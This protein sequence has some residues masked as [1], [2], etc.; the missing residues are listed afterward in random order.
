MPICC[1]KV[2]PLTAENLRA[3][4][5][6]W[7]EQQRRPK[8][9]HVFE[10]ATMSRIMETEAATRRDQSLAERSVAESHEPMRLH[11]VS[12]EDHLEVDVEVRLEPVAKDV[13][14]VLVNDR[15]VGWIHYVE[16][17]YVALVGGHLAH[18]VEVSQKLTLD[19]CI[20]ALVDTVPVDALVD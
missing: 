11:L 12:P 14:R 15:P 18:A 20:R 17:V 1:W 13:E 8:Q 9:C 2:K 19:S 10:G 6:R 16:P 4:R 3:Y 5:G 7:H